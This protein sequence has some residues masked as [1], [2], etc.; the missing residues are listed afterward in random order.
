MQKLLELAALIEKHAGPS[1]LTNVLPGIRLLRST[2]VTDP[3]AG[4]A[5]PTF[6]VVAQGAKQ[7]VIGDTVCDYRAGDSLVI[8][9]DVPVSAHVT[10]ASPEEPFLGFEMALDPAALAALAVETGLHPLTSDTDMGATVSPLPENLLD[11]LVRLLTL[12]DA[13]SDATALR[14]A[15][16][17]EVMWRLLT[18][19]HASVIRQIGL[20]GGPTSRIVQ[21]IAWLKQNF[22]EP[23]QVEDLASRAG[24][25]VTSFHRHFRRATSMTPIQYQKRVRLIHARTKLLSEQR[26]VASIGFEI[27]YESASQFNREYRR[28][29]GASPG[30]DAARFRSVGDVMR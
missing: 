20:E 19:E 27:G 2:R 24:M 10:K 16:E 14:P 29:F 7:T 23:V 8:S 18:G 28:E 11:A 30:V 3:L 25:S 22:A 6:A 13:P 4:L 21:A 15:I 17:R 1:Y 9:L 5:V 26:S 12:L